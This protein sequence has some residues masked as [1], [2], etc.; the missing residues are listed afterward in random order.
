MTA[1]FLFQYC[2][3]SLPEIPSSE[4]EAM[5]YLL[6]EDVYE[7]S[8]MDIAL[9][10]EL[11]LFDEDS[12]RQKLE[13]INAHEPIQHIIG[14][15]YFRNRQFYVSPD[16]LIPRPETEELI[17]H[18][19]QNLPILSPHILD[20]GTGTGCIPIS[21]SLEINNAKI[22]A[23]DISLKALEMAQKNASH[24]GANVDFIQNDFLNN[25]GALD[26]Y[27]DIIVSNPPY[28][29]QKE[30]SSMDANVLDFEPHVALFVDDQN[31]LVFYKA[32]A[33]YGQSHL[34][35]NGLIVVEINAHLGQE[36]ADVFKKE[37]YK[38]VKLLKDFYDKDRFILAKK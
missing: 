14:F 6:L 37:G 8:K 36:T 1:T 23:I 34:N 38:E 27:F 30:K 24:L 25:S 5:A 33:N 13:R 32:I 11:K 10:K 29:A 18:V 20:I 4:R 26:A 3:K 31:P 22:T 19:I 12:L 21:L 17:D 15:T 35:Q 28:I 9:S 2:L 7:I 16:V